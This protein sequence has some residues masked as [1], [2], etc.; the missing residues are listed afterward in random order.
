MNFY[1]TIL[2]I[3]L[4]IVF[5]GCMMKNYQNAIKVN[6]QKEYYQFINSY[7]DDKN[8]K[9]QQLVNSSWKNIDK[10]QFRKA[11]D[12]ATVTSY[13]QYIS[14]DPSIGPIVPKYIK[15]HTEE[16]IKTHDSLLYRRM[17]SI[18]EFEKAVEDYRNHCELCKIETPRQEL[19]EYESIAYSSVY[20][21]SSDG[22]IELAK[23]H[24][25][26]TILLEA[27]QTDF[28]NLN[29]YEKFIN[30]NN[31]NFCADGTL[32]VESLNAQF[33]TLKSLIRLDSVNTYAYNLKSLS[34]Y[35][36]FP[37]QGLHSPDR[38]LHYSSKRPVVHRK[39]VQTIKREIRAKTVYAES[40]VDAK[41]EST[42]DSL[43]F[44]F[45]IPE[46]EEKLSPT[47]IKYK[48]E[49]TRLLIIE[50]MGFKTK[51]EHKKWS[52]PWIKRVL[53]YPSKKSI[54]SYL[55]VRMNRRISS[56]NKR[57]ILVDI[58]EDQVRVRFPKR[59]SFLQKT[60][61]EES[62][63]K[64]EMM[65][66]KK[67]SQEESTITEA[68][69]PKDIENLIK[70]VSLH[71]NSISKS[72]KFDDKIRFYMNTL[73][74]SYHY[75]LIF[76][77]H[78][79][80]LK[81]KSERL[82][83]IWTEIYQSLQVEQLDNQLEDLAYVTTSIKNDHLKKMG[84]KDQYFKKIQEQVVQSALK[85]ANDTYR[86]LQK[87]RFKDY[88]TKLTSKYYSE[89][90]FSNGEKMTVDTFTCSLNDQL[91]KRCTDQVS[92]VKTLSYY[93][94]QACESP[95]L[96]SIKDVCDQGK[97]YFKTCVDHLRPEGSKRLKQQKRQITKEI[98]KQIKAGN[99]D[100][101]FDAES[102]EY[103][104]PKEYACLNFN[105]LY[106]LFFRGE[107]VRF[108]SQKAKLIKSVIALA[109]SQHTSD[110]YEKYF[111]VVDLLI[112][113]TSL[114]EQEI[115]K[116]QF[117]KLVFGFDVV[118]A[119]LKSFNK[120]IREL[121]AGEIMLGKVGLIKALFQPITVGE[122]TTEI[123]IKQSILDDVNKQR[124]KMINLLVKMGMPYALKRVYKLD[125]DETNYYETAKKN[126]IKKIL[127]NKKYFTQFGLYFSL[128]SLFSKTEL[129]LSALPK[130]FKNKV[131]K[132]QEDRLHKFSKKLRILRLK[133]C[134]I[135]SRKSYQTYESEKCSKDDEEYCPIDKRRYRSNIKYKSMIFRL[136]IN[137][138]NVSFKSIQGEQLL[139]S[140]DFNQCE[141]E[142]NDQQANILT[143]LEQ[144][145]IPTKGHVLKES[146]NEGELQ[147]QKLLKKDAIVVG[148]VEN[149]VHIFAR[150]G[151]ITDES[152]SSTEGE[153]E[154][155]YDEKD[156]SSEA[157]NHQSTLYFNGQKYNNFTDVIS[158]TDGLNVQASG[159]YYKNKLHG[160]LTHY[161][162]D[163]DVD[164]NDSAE[165][166]KSDEIILFFN[167]GKRIQKAVRSM[168]TSD[169]SEEKSSSL[170]IEYKNKKPVYM[171]GDQ[172]IHFKRN[173]P[174]LWSTNGMIVQGK[175]KVIPSKNVSINHDDGSHIMNKSG[176]WIL[177]DSS[178]DDETKDKIKNQTIKVKYRSK[179][180]KCTQYKISYDA[181][182]HLK[183]ARVYRYVE[184]YEKFK[185][186]VKYDLKWNKTRIHKGRIYIKRVRERRGRRYSI[187]VPF[188]DER[189]YKKR[190]GALQILK[191]VD[192]I[193]CEEIDAVIK[194]LD[195][196]IDFDLNIGEVINKAEKYMKP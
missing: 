125:E 28:K 113:S 190:K 128:K 116:P 26:S 111:A 105:Q 126:L 142:E 181:Q 9:I 162:K 12:T 114:T 85:I 127:K 34:R 100:P 168:N 92:D 166:I 70:I 121:Y 152:V 46:G 48:V 136:E 83:W 186:Q 148:Y 191:C 154:D 174:S 187:F 18:S 144:S 140:L 7:K 65:L 184:E 101:F 58:I 30:S 10:L 122:R 106:K 54:K 66:S 73:I 95:L 156:G 27:T 4:V 76:P 138:T 151:V 23:S 183:S 86:T 81:I 45:S 60:S 109:K 167:H 38:R 63:E 135:H 170:I 131:E 112:K 42:Q 97:T 24:L 155:S 32:K 67:G 145:V 104:P 132:S 84:I 25:C 33:L 90:S 161:T 141:D 43:D 123:P 115:T 103:L 22:H 52:D 50:V 13:K 82:K 196:L 192:E 134:K 163:I 130:S 172:V 19:D 75:Q 120:S 47:S 3:F 1:K 59:G 55:K 15:Q 182:G 107:L 16:A 61:V 178:C 37:E 6:Q 51:R 173:G 157:D 188:R 93:S 153:E 195:S 118:K 11:K 98:I 74:T 79:N 177:I 119:S 137:E 88:F 143:Y 179:D 96:D 94:T 108:K 53:I 193:G 146:F 2:M 40:F 69:Q 35:I 176:T 89:L 110:F 57:G 56:K 72:D 41:F 87:T 71:I 147:S 164:W 62:K 171:S 17:L 149:Q 31:F 139:L 169:D 124:E 165:T 21:E 44:I 194:N 36:N 91:K 77:D 5:A 102:E 117:S 29:Q 8:S 189:I 175:L 14:G 39:R 133:L 158:S 150:S 20:E 80:I 68:T 99:A 78:V 185:D 129:D 49:G 64:N 160:R 180:I 159:V